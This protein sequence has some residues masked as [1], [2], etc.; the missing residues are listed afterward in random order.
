LGLKSQDK[1]YP[2]STKCPLTIV[3]S[4]LLIVHCNTPLLTPPL[5]GVGQYYNIEHG[6]RIVRVFVLRSAEMIPLRG[7]GC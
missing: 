1:R 5:A 7:K 4:S 6:R 2:I 3:H